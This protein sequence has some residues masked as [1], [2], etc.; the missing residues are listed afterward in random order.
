MTFV[1]VIQ[2]ILNFIVLQQFLEEIHCCD[3]DCDCHYCHK[4]LGITAPN[5]QDPDDEVNEFLG[6]SIEAR[7]IDK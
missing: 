7:S 4:R 2:Q 1:I 6:S 3:Y 5:Q